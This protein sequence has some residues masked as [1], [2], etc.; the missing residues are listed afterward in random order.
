MASDSPVTQV[1]VAPR[2]ALRRLVTEGLVRGLDDAAIDRLRDECWDGSEEQLEDAGVLGVLTMFYETPDRGA[3]DGWVWHALEFWHDTD[4]AVGELA[5]ALRDDRPMFKQI[6]CDPIDDAGP[7]ALVELERDD[8]ARSQV[9]ARS[10]ADLAFAFNEELRARGR[11]KRLLRLE[12]NGDWEMFVAIDLRLARKLV[13]EGV[14]PIASI[15]D[16]SD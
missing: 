9:A 2:D 5:A 6:G 13:A 14:L 11:P 8:G 1:Y 15:D 3:K 10:L 7:A 12:T 4:D 16:L